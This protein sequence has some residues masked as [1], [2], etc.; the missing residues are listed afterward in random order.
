MSYP[1][2]NDPEFYNKITN[3]QEFYD[4]RLEN[5]PNK[6]ITY[7]ENHQSFVRNY[8]SPFT[9]YKSLLMFYETGVG[10]SCASIAVAE[11]HRNKG[12]N[13]FVLTKNDTI[14]KNFINELTFTECSNYVNHDN[15]NTIKGP[16]TLFKKQ[17]VARIKKEI[18]KHYQFM[19]YM[20]F[21]NRTIGRKENNQQRT[22]IGEKI[23]NLNNYLIIIDEAHNITNTETFNA[24]INVLNKSS[25]YKLLLLSATPM[26][27][28]PIEIFQINQLL[29][30]IKVNIPLTPDILL[31]KEF[32]KKSNNLFTVTKL[33]QDYLRKKLKGKISHL[34][35][36]P[37]TFPESIEIG[38]SLYDKPGSIKI[39]KSPMSKHQEEGYSKALQLDTNDAFFKQSSDAATIVYPDGSFGSS[40]FL[41]Q[42]NFKFLNIDRVKEYSSKLFNILN[43]LENNPGIAFIYS[44]FVNNAGTAL[45]AKALQENGYSKFPSGNNYKRYILL[46]S[47]ITTETKEVLRSK[48]NHP[49]NKDGKNISIIIGSPV[50]SEGITFKNI[51]QIHIL[52]PAWNYSRIIQIIGRGIRNN[53]HKILSSKDKN[54]SIFKY[55]STS[56]TTS[57]DVD[58]LKYQISESKDRSI[59]TIERLLKTIAVDCTLFSKRNILNSKFNN[60]RQCDYIQC[61][62]NCQ[63]KFNKLD[64]SSN[65]KQT[66]QEVINQI[67][68]LIL[69]LFNKYHYLT[70]EDIVN[71][72][73]SSE[74]KS[75]QDALDILISNQSIIKN[76]QSGEGT[77]MYVSGEVDNKM[78]GIYFFNPLN[79]DPNS[80][81]FKNIFPS[82]PKEKPTNIESFF[83][84][85]NIQPEVEPDLPQQ[86]I[87]IVEV[88]TDADIYGTLLNRYGKK[89]DK[90]RIID[91]RNVQNVIKNKSKNITGTVCSSL[92]LSQL[93]DIIKHLKLETQ[94]PSKDNYCKRIQNYLKNKN[95]LIE[96]E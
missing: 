23:T 59:K 13:I 18:Y 56:N 62:Y 14:K 88:N 96:N 68:H 50:I 5:S 35:T 91:K 46:D 25:N 90:F 61:D 39:I 16:N 82:K 22:I 57:I 76:K 41:K 26:V 79:S 84:I 53:S 38:D 78:V 21:V 71:K 72:I 77:L 60:T 29:N 92:S 75:I 12:T 48:L 27:D 30:P 33:G 63:S 80:T 2:I 28:S 93:T 87:Q 9:H 8:I 7:L 70:Y 54:V 69:K 1:E 11:R 15:I 45:V 51:R 58:I 20:S 89:D 47:N 49:D 95:L 67:I 32:I 52:E 94:S 66:R 65:T 74:I 44:S 3:K 85:L 73:S 10:K 86:N 37:D 81:L 31:T 40:G 34:R 24:L 55:A 36:N 42:K 19:T 64:K 43:N 83:K 4:F 6:D 17:E